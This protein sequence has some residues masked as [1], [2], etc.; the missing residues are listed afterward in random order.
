[1]CYKYSLVLGRNDM[2]KCKIGWDS[3][4]LVNIRQ[5]PLTDASETIE[6]EFIMKFSEGILQISET[7]WASET[8]ESRI[9]AL[10]GCPWYVSLLNFNRICIC[11]ILACKEVKNCSLQFSHVYKGA[12]ITLTNLCSLFDSQSP[13][14]L[15][16]FH[17]LIFSILGRFWHSQLYRS[18]VYSSLITRQS[19]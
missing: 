1:M 17:I 18:S 4:T 5:R 16:K 19:N 6:F 15:T 3:K 7:F 14:L 8:C 11:G 2:A 9:S 13:H 12:S 10:I